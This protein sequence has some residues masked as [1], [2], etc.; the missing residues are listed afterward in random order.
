MRRHAVR[1]PSQDG[2]A[3]SLR[4]AGGARGLIF[5]WWS[6]EGR[7]PQWSLPDDPREE[8]GW[9]DFE[10]RTLRFA[11]HPQETTENSVDLVHLRYV[12]G[13]DSVDRIGRLSVDGACLESD[14][15]F[16]RVRTIARVASL[17]FN[18]SANTRIYGLGYS[19]VKIREHSIG[20]DM[21][22]RSM[23]ER[24]WEELDV[25]IEDVY[26]RHEEEEASS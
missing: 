21:R 24:E 18:I 25:A 5:A 20:M 15:D 11:G 13:Y 9:T 8:P 10:I 16:K 26:R 3:A 1:R 23:V 22:L 17:T 4:D 7:A 12:H 19:Y 14:F 6:I 2:E